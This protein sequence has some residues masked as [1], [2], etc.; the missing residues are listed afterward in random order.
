M[1]A[2]KV[3]QFFISER[4][5]PHSIWYTKYDRKS[6][7][8]GYRNRLILCRYILYRRAN[9]LLE[10]ETDHGSLPRLGLTVFMCIG[11]RIVEEEKSESS[12]RFK[13]LYSFRNFIASK[14]LTHLPVLNIKRACSAYFVVKHAGN[15]AVD[16]CVLV[17]RNHVALIMWFE[18]RRHHAL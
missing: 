17:L 14:L 11:I 7:T 6:T 8:F 1:R 18:G 15:V 9:S 13:A 10:A 3:E 16:G 5:K 12:P 2:R 4:H